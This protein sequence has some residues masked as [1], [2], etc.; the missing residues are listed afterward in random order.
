MDESKLIRKAKEG[1]KAAIAE[2]F[3]QHKSKM[4][5]V[6]FNILGNESDAEEITSDAFMNGIK[7]FKP[8]KGAELSTWL[9]RVTTTASLSKIRKRKS[10]TV[11]DWEPDYEKGGYKKKDV[12]IFVEPKEG[13][14]ID[15]VMDNAKKDEWLK[16]V[17]AINHIIDDY[18]DRIPPKI[19]RGRKPAFNPFQD[20]PS[21]EEYIKLMEEIRGESA[22]GHVADDPNKKGERIMLYLRG[23]RWELRHIKEDKNIP[24]LTEVAKQTQRKEM[25]KKLNMRPGTL[26]VAIHRV[27]GKKDG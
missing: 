21:P 7:T 2:L 13:E 15:A 23:D 14:N 25:A 4:H 26:N 16:N 12:S 11:E 3:T 6:A 19:R 18:P 9:Y 20:T 24:L 22:S 10:E 27:K 5:R 8:G 1:N 17:D